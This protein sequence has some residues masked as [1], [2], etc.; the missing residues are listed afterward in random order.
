MRY[1]ECYD[2]NGTISGKH[3]ETPILPPVHVSVQ[4]NRPHNKIQSLIINLKIIFFDQKV[5]F[6]HCL[7]ENYR[8]FSR[9]E[10]KNTLAMY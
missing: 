10:S 1:Y 5:N 2:Y 4:M 9:S 8:K 3:Y 6:F 7:M